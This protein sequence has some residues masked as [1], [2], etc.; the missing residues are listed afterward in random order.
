LSWALVTSFAADKTLDLPKI[1][2]QLLYIDDRETT[3][4]A[5]RLRGFQAMFVRTVKEDI[6]REEGNPR[7]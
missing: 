1:A 6:P 5:F 7:E 3:E 4:N 2:Q